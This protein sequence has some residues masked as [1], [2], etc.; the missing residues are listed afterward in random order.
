MS[1]YSLE[2]IQA[3]VRSYLD[4]PKKA[5]KKLTEED[6]HR[7]IRQIMRSRHSN[8]QN[9]HDVLWRP[10]E[11]GEPARFSLVPPSDSRPGGDHFYETFSSLLPPLN[12]EKGYF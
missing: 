2:A 6:N 10:R 5:L 4:D 3:A 7:R 8:K 12:F 9:N 1:R 11:Q